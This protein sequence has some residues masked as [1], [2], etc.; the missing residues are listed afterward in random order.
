MT[1]LDPETIELIKETVHQTHKFSPKTK[2]NEVIIQGGISLT[3]FL[4]VALV[5]SVIMYGITLIWNLILN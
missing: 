5:A 1:N 2:L 3:A 4:I